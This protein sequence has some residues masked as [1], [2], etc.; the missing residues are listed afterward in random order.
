MAMYALGVS[1]LIDH[2][3]QLNQTKQIWYADDCP[4]S[5]SI[6]DLHHWWLTLTA[7]GSK[8][9]YFPKPSKS[10]LL[11]KSDHIDKAKELFQYTNIS[12]TSE[13]RPILGS[14]IGSDDFISNWIN[15]KVE[16]W[17]SELQSLTA[18]SETQ[19]Q[20]VF[21]ALTHGAM[22]SWTYLSRTCPEIGP[23]L[24]PLEDVLRK[25]LIPSL[26]SHD[27]PN[28]TMRELFALPCRHGGLGIPNPS[29]KASSHYE[30]SLSVC[31]PMITLVLAQNSLLSPDVTEQQQKTK[32]LI[33]SANRNRSKQQSILVREKLLPH[34]QKLFDI[35]NEKGVSSWLTALPIKPHGFDLHKGAFRD[36]L[37][38]RYG[39]TPSSLPTSCVC[40]SAFSV[41]HAFNCP[42]GGF[43]TIRHDGIK[44]I[45]ANLMKEVCRH[46][47]IKPTLQPLSGENL[48]PA[49]ANR[50]NEA[51]LD[52]K[53][54]GFWDCNYQSAYFDVR[55]FNPTAH[56]CRNR[57]L[58]AN[59]RRHEMEKRRQYEDRVIQ[60]E[61][62]VFTPLVFSTAGSVGPAATIVLNR[63]SS[64]LATKWNIG[65]NKIISWIRCKIGFALNHSAIMCLRG[66][67]SRRPVPELDPH[68]VDLALHQSRITA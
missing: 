34:Q 45:T 17:I 51:R 23:L 66:T 67:R 56:A 50:S 13:G 4:A 41:D 64:L 46:V 5:G 12:I 54:D 62:G 39:W 58:S 22:S 47:A 7:T 15:N 60:V 36:C 55:I 16:T 44:D 37:C 49:S 19:P 25:K 48:I 68:N 30:N 32:S 43:P 10:W 59:H 20:A 18:I 24:Q 11:V 1:P 63:L 29:L 31:N 28:N 42:H 38:L 14:P 61:H 35:S 26:T 9:G 6:D 3:S 65:Y 57:T 33:H 40:G 53:A 52:I 27:P 2:M 21:S 8:Y